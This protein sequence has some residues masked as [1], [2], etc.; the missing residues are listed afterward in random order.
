MWDIPFLHQAPYFRLLLPQGIVLVE[1]LDRINGVIVPAQRFVT[2]KLIEN[3]CTVWQYGESR[4][5]LWCDDWPFLQVDIVNV[6]SLEYVG[7]CQPGDAAADDD[8]LER[9]HNWSAQRKTERIKWYRPGR[10]V[11]ESEE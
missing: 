4:T 1:R 9:A 10:E 2:A 3:A 6:V 5:Q 8:Y 7:Q 11:D